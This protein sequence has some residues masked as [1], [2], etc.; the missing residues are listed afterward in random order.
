MKKIDHFYK[1]LDIENFMSKIT[2]FIDML[3]KD[4]PPKPPIDCKC[5]MHKFFYNE[6]AL[7]YK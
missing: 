7:K 1:N 6:Q 3:N 5:H 2:E 4:S